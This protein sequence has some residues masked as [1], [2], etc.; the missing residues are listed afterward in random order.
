MIFAFAFGYM[1]VSIAN[2]QTLLERLEQGLDIEPV[3][4]I[5]EGNVIAQTNLDEL[6]FLVAGVDSPDLN[7]I[8]AS[9]SGNTGI[10]SD[11]MMLCK[12]NFQDGSI[13]IMSLPRDSR[14]PI[15]GS[16]D[17]LGHA[18]SYGGMK[19]LMQTVRDFTN[20]DV[21]Y[22]VRV[23]YNAVKA[24]V[25]AIG[26]V[27]I[28]VTEPMHY[29]DTTKNKE[30]F[31]HFEPGLHVLDGQEAIEYLRFR[32]YRDGDETRVKNQQYFVKELIKQTLKPRNILR[33]PKLVDAYSKYIDTNIDS[34]I[35]Y[36][37]IGLASSL[38]G[39]SIETSTLPGQGGKDP[40][41]GISYFYIYENE[42][43]EAIEETFG[44]Y[45][46]D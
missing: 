46:M 24:I 19:L 14:V 45:L 43:K 30:L 38:D 13:D 20:L 5:E 7:K 33:L 44:D 35:I 9:N 15:K 34:G 36:K 41:T 25:D 3:E 8:K 1:Y 29:E 11:T 27:E 18:H 37:G 28:E 10:R 31:I 17:K 32:T 42:A 39:D 26:G 4:N 22:Y 23:D 12:V 40:A 6:L 2:N 21:D 16:L